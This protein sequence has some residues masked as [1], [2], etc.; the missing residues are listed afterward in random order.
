AVVGRG[1]RSPALRNAERVDLGSQRLAART[2]IDAAKGPRAA[3]RHDVHALQI[4]GGARALESRVDFAFA[5][6]RRRVP[7][8]AVG[9]TLLDERRRAPLREPI[10]HLLTK[11]V[12]VGLLG[13]GSSL[14]PWAFGRFCLR[15][16]SCRRI[17][18]GR[19]RRRL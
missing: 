10:A 8:I 19:T 6:R 14:A 9:P 17:G 3:A 2:G 7:L 12:G 13:R 16:G 11:L 1:E 15:I 4:L 5:A 18:L